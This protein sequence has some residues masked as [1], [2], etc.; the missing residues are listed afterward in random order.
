MATIAG[1]GIYGVGH[2]TILPLV[3]DATSPT[4][5][6]GDGDTGF[7]ESVDDTLRFAAGGVL[8][9]TFSAS[10]ISTP[11]GGVLLNE[12]PTTTNPSV[13]PVGNDTDTGIGRAGSDEL[14][15]IAGGVEAIRIAES[16]TIITSM[17]GSVR[18]ALSGAKWALLDE[19]PSDTNPVVIPASDDLDTGIGHQGADVLSLIAGGIEGIR[20]TESGSITSFQITGAIT[21][22]TGLNAVCF[23][24]QVVC[25]EN[26]IVFN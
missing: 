1:K 9:A 18:G 21:N 12:S 13:I 22:V 23:E 17:I 2:Q 7:Y 24:N 16:T 6:F 11:T 19:T 20:I 4:L 3:N 8:S 25:F 14:S 10:L 15:I 26:E 5:A